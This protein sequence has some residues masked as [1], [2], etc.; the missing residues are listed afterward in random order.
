MRYLGQDGTATLPGDGYCKI[1]DAAK[2]LVFKHVQSA[3][4]NSEC[5]VFNFFAR[6]IPQ[7]GLARIERR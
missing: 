2:D 1:H 4:I 7:E 6:K 5:K 3:G